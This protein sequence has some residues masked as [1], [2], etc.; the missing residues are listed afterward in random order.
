MA[1]LG[2]KGKIPGSENTPVHGAVNSALETAQ[3]FVGNVDS[4]LRSGVGNVESDVRGAIGGVESGVRGGIGNV[5]SA[6]GGIF[7][8]GSEQ[9]ASPASPAP[10]RPITQ[11]TSST[12]VSSPA[13]SARP[14][15]V[16][17]MASKMGGA[18][19]KG[20]LGGTSMSNPGVASASGSSATSKQKGKKASQRK[21]GK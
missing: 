6:L 9:S 16:N 5:A 10:A 17:S 7:G 12:M 11:P 18:P 2:T 21:K 13:A 14:L 20:G 15:V 3:D 4:N 19:V 1:G 8:G